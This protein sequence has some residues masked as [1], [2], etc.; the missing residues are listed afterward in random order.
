MAYDEILAHRITS[1]LIR[2][3]QTGIIPGFAEKKMFGG[4]CYT[5]L[6]K[7]ACGVNRNNLI[8]RL[9]PAEYAQNLQRPHARPFDMT[10]KPMK[11][12][13][14]V[15]EPGTSSDADLFDWVSQGVVFAMSLPSK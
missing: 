5:V 8:V 15:A 11:G 12:W 4:I 14:V 2:I 10:G 1:A 3:S 9:D 7:M 13:I 6:G